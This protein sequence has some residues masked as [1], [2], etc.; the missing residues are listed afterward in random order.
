MNAH[1]H[2]TM[3]AA[4]T[5]VLQA[6]FRAPRERRETVMYGGAEFEV[7]YDYSPPEKA[8]HDVESPLCGPGCPASVDVYAI[9]HK[10]DEVTDAID[11]DVKTW[12]EQDVLRQMGEA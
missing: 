1:I 9:Y 10:G 4:L 7:A 2:P 5:P 6:A 8:V 11:P 3:Q 12:M